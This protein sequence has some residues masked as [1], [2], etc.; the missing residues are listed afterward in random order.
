MC[1][2]D[3]QKE[4]WRDKKEGSSLE[5]IL[6]RI[7]ASEEATQQKAALANQTAASRNLFKSDKS[8]PSPPLD[9]NT[10]GFCGKPG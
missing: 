9:K 6:D 7:R 8:S 3:L 2:K 10:C 1:D 4:L 5:D